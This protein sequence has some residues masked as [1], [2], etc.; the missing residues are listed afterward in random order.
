M[1]T[2][3]GTVGALTMAGGPVGQPTIALV[4]TMAVTVVILV[5]PVSLVT[6]F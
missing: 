1:A 6:D 3:D 2:I 4:M 5:M